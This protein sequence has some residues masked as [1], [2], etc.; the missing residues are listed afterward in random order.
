MRTISCLF[1]QL[2][3]KI[4]LKLT[5][6]NTITGVMT[7]KTILHYKTVISLRNYL[8]IFGFMVVVKHVLSLEPLQ[9]SSS[10]TG[11]FFI[12]LHSDSACNK[13]RSFKRT[14]HQH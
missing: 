11:V 1:D 3:F 8:K 6:I 2:T 13:F 5:V 7:I 12:R 14:I 10:K 4:D 9:I